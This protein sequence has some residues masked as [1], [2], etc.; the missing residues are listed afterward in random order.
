MRSLCVEGWRGINHSYAMVNQ[1]QLAQLRS[2]DL[3]LYHRDLPFYNPNW[4]QERNAHGLAPEVYGG[5]A[6]IPAPPDDRPSD[7]TYRISF[8]YRMYPSSSSR[9]FV[10][11]TSEFQNIDGMV[12]ED[13]LREGLNNPNLQIIA[14]SGWSA[15]GFRRAG[16]DDSRVVIVPH[17]VDPEA[18]KPVSATARAQFR[19]ALGIADG[20]F[21]ILSVGAMTPNKGIERLVIAYALLRRRHEQARLVLKD[22]SNLYGIRAKEIVDRLKI[23]QPQLVDDRLDAS[24]VYISQ[25]VTV[26]QLRGLYGA[27][28]C[29]AS[30][31]L[32]EGF[33]LTPLEAAACGTPIV[34]TRGGSTDDYV[35]DSFALLVEGTKRSSGTS[36]WIEPSIDSLL[37]QLSTLAESRAQRIDARRAVELIGRRFS[38]A[39]AVD[40]LVD[41]MF[42]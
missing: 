27:A 1:Y 26:E 29:Y 5:I 42:A 12:H 11:G 16:F 4:T 33:N 37:H 40:R 35:D 25:N 39:A 31:Y 6:G 24:I 15:E 28:D 17:G 30:P 32:A 23:Q 2:R 36:S 41:E 13:G 19:R 20:E 10:F 7:V 14:P 21:A 38:W 34:V 18:F 9:L 8:P 22:Q 3:E